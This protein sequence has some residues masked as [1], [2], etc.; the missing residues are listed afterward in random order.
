MPASSAISEITDQ[1]R[2][3]ALGAFPTWSS[4]GQLLV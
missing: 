1:T 4:G 2:T 3:L